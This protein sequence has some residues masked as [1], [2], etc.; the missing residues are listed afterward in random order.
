MSE[1]EQVK[2]QSGVSNVA[3][4]SLNTSEL[5]SL[6]NLELSALVAERVM[7]WEPEMDVRELVRLNQYLTPEERAEAPAR[8]LRNPAGGWAIT[9][10]EFATDITSAFLVIE[11]LEADGWA[12]MISNRFGTYEKGAPFFWRMCFHRFNSGMF[13]GI[14]NSAA[15]AIC[16]AAI[17]ATASSASDAPLQSDAE[18]A[19]S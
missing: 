5:E 3:I 9:P 6:S 15:R 18:I 8:W 13:D 17:Q 2:A 12:C 14:A 1:Q 16:L 7:G 19:A 10:V 4:E 11:K